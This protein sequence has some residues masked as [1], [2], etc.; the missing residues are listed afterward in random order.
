M[1]L[2]NVSVQQRKKKKKKAEEAGFERKSYLV[3]M[4][5]LRINTESEK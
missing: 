1:N 2:H 4:A 5:E 3:N